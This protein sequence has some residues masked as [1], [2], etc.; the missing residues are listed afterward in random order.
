MTIVNGRHRQIAISIA[1]LIAATALYAAE[2]KEPTGSHNVVWTSPGKDSRGSMPIGNGD[3]GANVWVEENGDLLFYLSKSDA[4]SENCRP[5]K[6]G[7]PDLEL[8]RRTFA[9]RAIKKTG[10]WQQNA[11]KAAYLGLADEVIC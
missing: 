6:L 8:G 1:W 4:W 5:P 7:K 11:I 9:Q 10:G 2:G 3:I